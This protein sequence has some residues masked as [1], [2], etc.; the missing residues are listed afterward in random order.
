[1][2]YIRPEV[3]VSYSIDALVADAAACGL[4]VVT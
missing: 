4:Y 2:S 3:I 1:M